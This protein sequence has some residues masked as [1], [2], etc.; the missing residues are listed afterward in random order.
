MSI[1]SI[2][3]SQIYFLNSTPLKKSVESNQT[4]TPMNVSSSITQT[5]SP[6][7]FTKIFLTQ[8]PNVS[9]GKRY[10]YGHDD[11]SDYYN[12]K[13]PQPPDIEIKKYQISCQ[14]LNDIEDENYL[15]AI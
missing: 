10:N 15:E 8:M 11:L 5:R 12:Y 13:G 4:I 9:F 14:I 3:N 6:L 2:N 7:P 1:E